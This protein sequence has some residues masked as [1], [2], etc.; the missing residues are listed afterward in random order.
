MAHPQTDKHTGIQIRGRT[1]GESTRQR[2]VDAAASLMAEAGEKAISL[3]QAA[4]RAGVTR[5]TAYH[6]FRK[7]ENLVAAAH[8]EIRARSEQAV[9][10]NTAEPNP[11]V[12]MADVLN[13]GPDQMRQWAYEALD[14]GFFEQPMFN[15]IRTRMEEIDETGMLLQ[16]VDIEMA[17][18]LMTCW[19]IL[20][21]A[22][23]SQM[24]PDEEKEKAL[25]ERMVAEGTRIALRAFVDC[26]KS[27][28]SAEWLAGAAN[29][30][31]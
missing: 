5:G 8:D 14:G 1:R 20:A 31:C 29:K 2:I 26:E 19:M 11:S 28:V 18:L 22:A 10:T 27:K 30:A 4:A 7:R 13:I 21:R 3:S 24:A 25:A 9:F 12:F 23:T 17:S 16:E 15:H 6:H